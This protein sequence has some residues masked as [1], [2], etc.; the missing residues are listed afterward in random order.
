MSAEGTVRRGLNRTGGVGRGEAHAALD[1]LVAERDQQ[2]VLTK[3]YIKKH[4]AVVEELW[5]TRAERDRATRELANT[6]AAYDAAVY[7]HGQCERNSDALIDRHR[8]AL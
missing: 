4:D 2:V 8:D 5:S 6:N 7:G 3:S 1:S